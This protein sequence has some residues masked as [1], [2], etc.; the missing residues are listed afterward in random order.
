MKSKCINVHDPQSPVYELTS[1]YDCRRAAVK[2][3]SMLLNLY[4]KHPEAKSLGPDG[5]PC[6][7]KT[8]GLLQRAHVGANGIIHI[9]KESDRHWEEAE[10][11]SLLEFRAIEYKAKCSAIATDEQLARI[12]MLPTREL[13]RRGISQHTL[14]KICKRKPVRVASLMKCL[15]ALEGRNKR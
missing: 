6:D 13:R 11:L 4:Q 10:D 7:Y 8:R 1:E 3:F 5:T 2:D 14:E 12:A 9:G 15:K